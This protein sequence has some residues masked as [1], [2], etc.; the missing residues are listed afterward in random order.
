MIATLREEI[1]RHD[2]LY[3]VEARPQIADREY[4]SLLKRLE[5]LEQQYPEL[6]SPDSPTQRVGGRPLDVFQQVRHAVPMMSL[7]NTYSRDEIVEFDRRVAKLAGSR[8]YSY[9]LEPKIDGLAVSLRYEQGVLVSGSTRGDGS[10]GDDITA[11]LRTI[12]SIPLRLES[13]DSPS[14]LEVRGEVFMPALGFEKLNRSRDEAGE[15]PFANPRNAAAGSLK[16]LDSRI[17]ATR[18][19]DAIFYA[20]GEVSGREFDTHSGLMAFLKG[21]RFKIAPR[22]WICRDI[23]ETLSAIDELK[24]AR[25]SFPFMIDGGVLKVNERGLYDLLGMTAKSPRWAVAYKYEPE[26]AETRLNDITVQVGR[27]GVLTPVA[28]LEPVLVAGSEVR[29]ATLHNIEEVR[30]KDIRI[31]DLVLI[32]K[33]GDV[34]PAI[35][36]VVVSARKGTEK[37]FSMPE[38][39]PVC[40]GPVSR[41]DDEVAHRCDNLQ[42][43]AQIKRWIRHF[44]QRGTMDIEGLGD[45]LID[46]LVDG[47]L[48]SDPSDLYSLTIG[49]LA[50]L[51][52]M[53]EK[54]A[55]NLQSAILASKARDMW[56]VLFGL[57]I[58]H[59]GAKSAQTIEM[60]FASIHE[61]MVADIASLSRMRDI[62]PVVARSI[63]ESLGNESMR[64]V[65]SRLERA[66]VNM[67]R[68]SEPVSAQGPLAG[69]TFVLTG[70]LDGLTR[71]DASELI[72]RKGGNVSSAVSAKTDYVVA[73][74]DAGSKLAKAGKLG[75]KVLDQQSFLKIVE[76]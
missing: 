7:A 15:E 69:K 63:F 54:S 9:V 29:R 34:I 37:E 62:G 66:G 4:D 76:G 56:R 57:G 11:N 74:A 17:V 27:T 23:E 12:K 18:P 48:V 59:V 65:V 50:D 10:V 44:A 28:E 16:L 30:R 64:K 45:A 19:L 72:R 73:G 14:V 60:H 43:P 41:K 35:V 61:V 1:A 3:Y 38:K 5:A 6:V 31:G 71:E 20:V 13:G 26:R 33:A 32:E 24:T 53:G 46:Q 55:A 2:H 70:T 8:S 22:S 25:H 68:L 39:C 52:R 21:L 36:E 51:D 58:R 40:S 42:C 47:G 67:V 75:I 49:Q